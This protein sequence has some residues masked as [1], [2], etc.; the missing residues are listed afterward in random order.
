MRGP[1]VT[2]AREWNLATRRLLDMADDAAFLVPVVI[3]ETREADARVPEEFLRAQWTR[4]PGGETP[5]AFAQ[6]VR[7]LLGLDRAPV[8]AAKAAATG[9]IE[10]SARRPGSVQPRGTPL[11]R[12]FGI[13]LIALLLV[14]G[15]GAV[16]YY[17]RH[18]RA[19]AAKSATSGRQLLQPPMKSRLRCCR[20]RT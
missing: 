1:R 12:R 4:L 9:A 14:L 16:W 2:S 11:V 3:D 13:P 6:R 15:G 17:R 18:E 5:P 19:P 8:P 20:S 7:Q 10:P